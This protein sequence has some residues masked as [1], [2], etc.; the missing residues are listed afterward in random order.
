MMAD[1]STVSVL[2]CQASPCF[3]FNQIGTSYFGLAL[4][5]T[6]YQHQEYNYNNK[7]REES[8]KCAI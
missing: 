1:F 7:E 8:V 2:F 3:F 5:Y 6:H 4:F